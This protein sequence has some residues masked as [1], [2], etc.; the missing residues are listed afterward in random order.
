MIAKLMEILATADNNEY[1]V[2][3]SHFARPNRFL[4]ERLRQPAAPLYEMG[5]SK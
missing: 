1:A 4:R 2:R 5:V 3:S